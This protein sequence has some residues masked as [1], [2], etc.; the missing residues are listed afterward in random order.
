VTHHPFI[1][2]NDHLDRLLISDRWLA[3][4]SIIPIGFDFMVYPFMIILLE[5]ERLIPPDRCSLIPIPDRSFVP[6]R[7]TNSDSGRIAYHCRLPAAASS[8]RFMNFM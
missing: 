3:D 7:A 5:S 4:I 8:L 2:S 1:L 6:D